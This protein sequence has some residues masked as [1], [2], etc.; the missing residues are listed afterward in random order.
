MARRGPSPM[1]TAVM[2]LIAGWLVV[3]AAVWWAAV[4]VR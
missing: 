2:V 1:A 3:M 4:A